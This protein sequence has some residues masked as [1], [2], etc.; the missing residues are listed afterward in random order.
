MAR[1]QQTKIT[2]S[3]ANREGED[4]RVLLH[5][6]NVELTPASAVLVRFVCGDRQTSHPATVSAEQPGVLLDVSVPGDAIEDGIWQLSY[7]PEGAER[8]V[9]IAARLLT[10]S[11]QPIALIPS[12]ED[13]S[14]KRRRPQP[15]KG[16][17]GPSRERGGGSPVASLL[18]KGS[19]ARRVAS[20][21][22]RE[23]RNR[24]R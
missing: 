1:V 21:V 10:S 23:I 11:R 9:T 17:T 3:R 18:H 13:D 7:R 15:P 4:V 24:I 12:M 6:P 20:R 19:R 14:P 8:F 2:R 5:L 22:R 16:R